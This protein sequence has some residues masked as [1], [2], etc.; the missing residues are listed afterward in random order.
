VR[1]GIADLHDDVDR[2]DRRQRPAPAQQRR[3]VESAHELGDDE[4]ARSGAGVE[5]GDDVGVRQLR[6]KL[7]FTAKAPPERRVTGM[8]LADD[9]DGHVTLELFVARAVDGR[10]A[11]RAEALDQ[12]V[13]AADEAPSGAPPCAIGVTVT[14]ARSP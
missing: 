10:H 4:V 2:L 13:A 5:D 1:K 6:A 11:A 14:C 7:R 8:A 3:G 12:P 9:L